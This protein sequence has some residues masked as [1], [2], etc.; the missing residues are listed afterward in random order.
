[1]TA[2]PVHNFAGMKAL[3]LHESEDVRSN[4]SGRL[5]RLGMLVDAQVG[6]LRPGSLDADILLIDI[7]RAYDEQLPWP[8][9]QAALPMVGL[10]GSESPG[11]LAW[12][13]RHEIDAYLPLSALAKVFSA[14]V[15]AHE[16]FSRKCARRDREASHAKVQSGRLDVVRAVLLLMDET[17][18][19][20]LALKKLRALAMIERITV[21]EAARSVISG[22][23]KLRRSES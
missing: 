9:G 7:D 3:V 20:A 15:I 18:D 19:E 14:L 17:G 2:A 6:E 4:L 8:A 16:T 1:M 10:I 21:E 5:A 23:T 12:A 13:L 11:R 22:W